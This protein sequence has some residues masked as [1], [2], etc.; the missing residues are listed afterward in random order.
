MFRIFVVILFLFTL[1]SPALASQSKIGYF[2]L[3][4]VV[5]LSQAGRAAHV[6]YMKLVQKYQV[7]IKEKSK[8][9]DTLRA[10]VKKLDSS[11]KGDA[12][13]PPSL[14][15]KNENVIRQFRNLKQLSNNDKEDLK[16]YSVEL[17]REVLRK[18]QPVLAKFA[19]RNGYD[20]LFVRNNG[21]AYV[22]K[23]DDVTKQVIE[24]FD[25]AYKK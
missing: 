21:L 25:K 7:A 18:F 17:T 23:R 12:A 13:A 16:E 20:F 5:S 4:K 14:V 9:L 11:I 24:A 2:D 1:V 19:R 6:K 22:N 15:A 3:Q 10:E 8:Q